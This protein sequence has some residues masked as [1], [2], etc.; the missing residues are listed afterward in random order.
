MLAN[1][2]YVID[3]DFSISFTQINSSVYPF[4]ILLILLETFVFSPTG[5]RK[6]ILACIKFLT[7]TQCSSWICVFKVA[8]SISQLLAP[9]TVIQGTLDSV[10]SSLAS[11][12]DH[13]CYESK[14]NSYLNAMRTRRPC[15]VPRP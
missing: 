5:K 8:T 15:M 13:L 2:T 12:H 14:G 9:T 1:T 3:S 10:I 7:V 11:K 4:Y 6:S